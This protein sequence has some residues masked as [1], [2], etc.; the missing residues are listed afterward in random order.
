MSQLQS[1]AN[2]EGSQGKKIEVL[3]LEFLNDHRHSLSLFGNKVYIYY[4]ITSSR[5]MWLV[6]NL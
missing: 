2:R 3:F 5:S 6:P 4:H 1:P